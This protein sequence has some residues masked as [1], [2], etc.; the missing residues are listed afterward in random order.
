[1]RV[2]SESESY[3]TLKIIKNIPNYNI[4]LSFCSYLYLNYIKYLKKYQFFLLFWTKIE[5]LPRKK[6]I[7]N[8]T[9]RKNVLFVPIMSSYIY[10][11]TTFSVQMIQIKKLY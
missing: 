4:F 7:Y 8:S 5:N 1:M 3:L 6:L 2:K 10:N 9:N 11:K